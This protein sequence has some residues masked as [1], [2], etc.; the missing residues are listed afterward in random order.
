MR[1]SITARL[2]AVIM[3]VLIALGGAAFTAAPASAA[4]AASRAFSACMDKYLVVQRKAYAAKQDKAATAILY[5]GYTYCYYD[6]SQRN[7][8]S[9]QTEINAINNYNRYRARAYQAITASVLT[10]YKSVLKSAGLRGLRM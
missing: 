9:G 5:T 10:Y 6:L 7:D 4:S 2:V 3:T 1:K 8:I